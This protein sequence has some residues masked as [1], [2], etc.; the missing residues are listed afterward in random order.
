MCVFQI[1]CGL[2]DGRLA[3]TCQFYVSSF[4]CRNDDTTRAQDLKDKSLPL[5]ENC[6]ELDRYYVKALLDIEREKVWFV[7]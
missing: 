1:L 4:N 7:K 6:H 2:G 5:I 3:W